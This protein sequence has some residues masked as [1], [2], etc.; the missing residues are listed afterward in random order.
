MRRFFN[1][2]F[3][4]QQLG[5]RAV[6]DQILVCRI[7]HG[8]VAVHFIGRCIRFVNNLIHVDMPVYNCAI[9]EQIIEDG[10]NLLIHGNRQL[11]QRLIVLPRRLIFF[12]IVVVGGG[13]NNRQHLIHRPAHSCAHPGL[14]IDTQLLP[15]RTGEVQLIDCLLAKPQAVIVHHVGAAA[16]EQGRPLLV[17]GIFGHPDHRIADWLHTVIPLHTRNNTVRIDLVSPYKMLEPESV[18]RLVAVYR[19]TDRGRS[20]FAGQHIGAGREPVAA[21]GDIIKQQNRFGGPECRRFRFGDFRR[22]LR[23]RA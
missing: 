18:R 21:P 17:L 7:E 3:K 15:L 23:R 22:L 14:D 20:G 13:C 1:Q 11:E 4:L 10:R 6:S 19:I 2:R 16:R 9:R 12:G 5:I 8:I